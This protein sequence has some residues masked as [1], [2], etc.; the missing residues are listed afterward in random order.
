[1]KTYPLKSI[2]LE[3]AI[4]K[5]FRMVDC[6]SR[7]FKG[8]E[9]L[10][11]GD[12]GVHQPENEPITTMKAEETIA[13]FF[14]A[15][16]SIM[17]RGSG[18]GAIRY[19]LSS[20]I[21]ANE[22]ILIHKAPVYSTTKTSFE[23]L[24]LIPVI[25]DFNDLENVRNVLKENDDIKACLIQYTRQAIEDSYDMKQVIETVKSLKDIPIITDDNYAVMKVEKIGTELG[26]D[27]SCFSCFKLQGPEG[28]GAI[29]GKKEYIAANTT[30]T[31]KLEMIGIFFLYITYAIYIND[32][33]S[34]KDAVSIIIYP[35]IVIILITLN[36]YT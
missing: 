4:E 7:H 31:P 27:L 25:A 14:D 2:S 32:T 5:Q 10:S 1:M 3:Q 24:G 8:S 26:A 20:V 28:I 36:I 23:M 19:A 30:Y 15:Q 35:P 13:S 33:L 9:L 11:R 18:T 34:S 21:K 29:V 6:I 16:A 12:L 17:V 22:K